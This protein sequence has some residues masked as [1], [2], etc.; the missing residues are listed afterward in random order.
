MTSTELRSE[1]VFSRS[2]DLLPTAP[3]DGGCPRVK[4]SKK[5]K[6][7]ILYV[8]TST[9]TRCEK[10]GISGYSKFSQWQSD[11]RHRPPMCNVVI[12]C[13]LGYR[14]DAAG[15]K[16]M[17][18]QQTPESQVGA[19]DDAVLVNRQEGVLRTTRIESACRSQH[20]RYDQLVAPNQ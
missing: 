19:F 16:G 4:G 14:I 6:F 12:E 11:G 3:V 2:A 1:Q 10:T 13:A 17:T 9:L 18:P 5:I 8:E 7:A 15:V 20:R